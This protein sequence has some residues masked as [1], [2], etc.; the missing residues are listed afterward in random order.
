[1]NRFR[2]D[3]G[4]PPALRG[5]LSSA[6][7]RL[8]FVAQLRLPADRRPADLLHAALSRLA[9][10]PLE[11]ASRP[12]GAGAA[13][14][15]TAASSGSPRASQIY[16]AA[17]ASQRPRSAR[18]IRSTASPPAISRRRCSTARRPACSGPLAHFLR[19]G[20]ARLSVDCPT[21][22]P[23]G[24]SAR[25]ARA[26]VYRLPLDER[27]GRR[28]S[29]RAARRS[30][31]SRSARIAA[32][33]ML[34]VLVRADGG[35]DAMWR[36]EVSRGRRRPASACRSTISATARAKCRASAI[37][38]CPAR[39]QTAGRS[40]IASSAIMSLY[41]GGVYARPGARRAT[42]V[43]APLRGGRDVRLALAHARRPDR[44]DRPRRDD[45]RRQPRRPRLHLD[46]A[47]GRPAPR[48]GDRYIHARSR[49]KARRAATPSSSAPI[50]QLRTALRA[51]SACRSR[52]GPIRRS[53]ASSEARR[54]WCSCAASTAA[55][56]RPESWPRRS[57]GVA[58]DDCHASCVDWYGN[59]RPIFLGGRPSPCSVTSWS[60]A[61]CGAG[62]P[63][64]RPGQLRAEAGRAGRGGNDSGEGQQLVPLGRKFAHRAAPSAASAI[65]AIARSSR[66]RAL[67][68]ISPTAAATAYH[69]V[70][71]AGAMERDVAAGRDHR[72]GA[73]GG[74]AR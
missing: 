53:S 71:L 59:A 55:C 6:L 17:V 12:S 40:T 45:R 49:A 69:L 46:R 20:H 57:E 47:A 44:G 74:V 72:R 5:R 37:G 19:V 58:D 52:A 4:R 51:C 3:A 21:P 31:N 63:R 28:R 38:R 26:F 11:A 30:I 10:D 62:D 73:L 42:L 32:D 68:P 65:V 14:P 33:G 56:R 66:S 24:A 29:A 61:G 22:G 1:M 13:M 50:R 64:G 48:L 36:P 34:N 39:R 27:A 7:Q 9:G 25:A 35:G 70:H 41:G 54:R 60:K 18:S 23:T 16:I 15:R 8:L 2:L 43:V 67:S